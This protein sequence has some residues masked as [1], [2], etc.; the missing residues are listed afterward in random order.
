MLNPDIITQIGRQIAEALPQSV[1]T[2]Q[3]E[4]EKTARVVLQTT[5]DKLDL[6]SREEF[7]NQVAVLKRT[8]EKLEAL[9]A[10]VNKL[11]SLQSQKTTRKK[12]PKRPQKTTE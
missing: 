5:I 9:E 11:E 10:T 7:D 6:V 4:L 3:Q 12:A 1:K 8:R 2:T